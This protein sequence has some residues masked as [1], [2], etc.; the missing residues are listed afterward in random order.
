MDV[1]LLTAQMLSDTRSRQD[2]VTQMRLDGSHAVHSASR[3]VRL[4]PYPKGPST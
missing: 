2:V 3:R 4:L 1:F